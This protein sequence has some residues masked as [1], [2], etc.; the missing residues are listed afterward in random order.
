MQQVDLMLREVG[1]AHAKTAQRAKAG[2]DAVDGAWLRG[3]FFHELAAATDERT[4]VVRQFA[5]GFLRGN[6]PGLGDGKFMSVKCNHR[7]LEADSTTNGLNT[8]ASRCLLSRVRGIHCKLNYSLAPSDGE[9]V[10]ERVG[11]RGF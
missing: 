8:Q 4:G 5:R 2:V 9:R 3:E 1:V 11:E 7:N 6:L 10:G